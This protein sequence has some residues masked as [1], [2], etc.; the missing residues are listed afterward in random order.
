MPIDQLHASLDRSTAVF[1]NDLS[2]EEQVDFR[3]KVKTYVRLYIFLSQIVPFENAYLERLYIF[4]NHL[5]SKLGG[6]T[7][8]D[9]A[10]GILDNIDMDSYRLQLEATVN[11]GLAQG[12]DLKPIPTEMR[13]GTSE[14]EIDRLSNILQTFNDR[15]GTQFENADKVRQ[16]VESIAQ[17][18]AKNEELLNS[19]K[20]S[21]DQNAR[22][23][24]D[25]IAQ[26]ELLK[27]V[28][29]NF[30]FYKLITDNEEA[31]EDFNSMLFSM[32]KEIFNKGLGKV[33]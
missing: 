21:D 8:E 10:Q 33:A 12:D 29:T 11:I 1:R 31:K 6:E 22:I 9:L 28:T 13:G 7:S 30:D 14:T 26:Q 24:N 18:V 5:Q 19:I 25:K 27:H 16:M 32:V 17:D 23:T 2:E 15:F 4:L 20:Y 3:A